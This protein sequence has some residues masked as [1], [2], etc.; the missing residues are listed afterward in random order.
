MTRTTFAAPQMDLGEYLLQRLAQ[1]GLG[2]IHGVPGD[3]N[4][5]VLDY[6]EPAGLHWVGNANELCA[7]YAADGYA[8][9]KGIGALITS[10]GVGELSAINAIG[11][12]YAEKAPVVHIVGTPPRAAQESGACLHHSLGDGNFRVFADMYKSVTCAQANLWDAS[13]APQLIDAT[14]KECLLQSRPVYIEI[15]TDLVRAKVPAPH[16]P[17]DLSS[18]DYDEGFEDKVVDSLVVRIQSCKQPLI[19]VDGFT[20]RFGVRDDINALVKLTGFPTL[21]TP[22]GK[23]IVDEKEPNFH[24]VYLGSAG[25]ESY[26][27]YVQGCDLVLHFGVLGSEVNTFGFTALPPPAATVT[28]DKYSV[29]LGT[30]EKVPAK[31]R[32]LSINTALSKLLRR[33]NGLE[34]PIPEPYP[35][36]PFLPREVLKSLPEPV[37]TASIDQYSLWLRMSWFLQPGDIVMTETGTASYGGQSIAL[38]DGTTLINSSIWLSIGYMLGACQGATLAQREMVKDGTRSPGRTILFEGDGSLQMTA[39]AI[40][41]IIRNKLDVTIFVLNNNGYTIERIIH[42]FSEAYNDIQPWRNL[43]APGY[44]GAVSGD[45]SYPVRTECAQNWGELQTILQRPDIQEGKGLN[46]IEILMSMDDAPESLRKF[47]EYLKKRN[48]AQL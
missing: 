46:M 44:F 23:S 48:S 35:E 43:Q 18:A 37:D 29:S 12:S 39:Q 15:P 22:F 26:Q 41:D 13:T 5:T 38:P 30:T 31:S 27:S 1:L 28:F 17:I 14:L 3:Y 16:V 9:I 2:S 47:V 45:A 6:L 8:R 36:D 34:I 25:G 21:T 32:L 19:L 40:S 24:G 7:G 11:A 4:L 33:L 20:A 10:F 42:G